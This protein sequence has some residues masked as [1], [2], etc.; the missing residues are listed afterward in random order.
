MPPGWQRSPFRLILACSRR[1]WQ[2][3]S[4]GPPRSCRARRDPRPGMDQYLAEC[5][6]GTRNSFYGAGEVNAF[7]A[8]K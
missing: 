5:T 7:N 1:R 3:S 8:V 2:R 4:S 6:G